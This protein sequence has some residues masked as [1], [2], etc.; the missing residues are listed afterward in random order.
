MENCDV[1]FCWWETVRSC[2]SMSGTVAQKK[3]MNPCKNYLNTSFNF[4]LACMSEFSDLG[5]MKNQWLFPQGSTPLPSLLARTEQ[6][7]TCTYLSMREIE[8][9]YYGVPLCCVLGICSGSVD[10][11][12]VLTLNRR[13]WQIC[14]VLKE[15]VLF[16]YG[17]LLQ[18]IPFN[19]NSIS[20]C[21]G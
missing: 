14:S 18:S 8:T 12:F 1:Q 4:S 11:F 16:Q 19:A 21:Y 5:Q 15:W 6:H 3:K 13:C 20:Q 2:F 7:W 9:P 10:F 17:N